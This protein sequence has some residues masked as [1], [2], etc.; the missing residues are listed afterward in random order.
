[1][2]K[3]P[4]SAKYLWALGVTALMFFG[5]VLDRGSPFLPYINHAVEL[6]KQQAPQPAEP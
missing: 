4:R 2:A 1:M 3:A 6:L 5:M